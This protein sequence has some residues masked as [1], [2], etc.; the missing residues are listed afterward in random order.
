MLIPCAPACRN[1]GGFT[2]LDASCLL[3]G[4]RRGAAPSAPLERLEV[5]DYANTLSRAGRGESA[6]VVVAPLVTCL[7]SATSLV[8]TLVLISG[9]AVPCSTTRCNPCRQRRAQR[10]H[11]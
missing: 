6:F 2:Y 10:R 4:R 7:S 9:V 3:Y 1:G 5:V 11:D 8:G